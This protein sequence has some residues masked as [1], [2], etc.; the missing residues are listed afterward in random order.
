MFYLTGYD[1]VLATLQHI[2]NKVH[3]HD[4]KEKIKFL[5]NFFEQRQFQNAVCVHHKVLDV[6]T[7]NP[8]VQCTCSTSQD[9]N[10]ECA[11]VLCSVQSLESAEL[12]TILTK[13]HMKV[14]MTILKNIAQTFTVGR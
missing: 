9:L 10:D 7:R 14:S 2:S 4:G 8:P 5:T 3:S 11:D 13:P 6:K 1:N 12:L